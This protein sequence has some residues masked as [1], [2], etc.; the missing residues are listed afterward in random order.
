MRG[1]WGR[2]GWK[3]L[4]FLTALA[5]MWWIAKRYLL[6]G[7]NLTDRE[8]WEARARLASL[9]KAPQWKPGASGLPPC[10]FVV[11]QSA[12]QQPVATGSISD[13]LLLVPDGRSLNLYEVPLG[14]RAVIPITTDLY[15]PDVIPLAFT[16]TC[17]PLDEWAKRHQVYLPHVYDPY[18]TGSRRPYNYSDWLLPDRQTIHYERISAGTGYADAI[19]EDDRLIPF[20]LG[21]RIKWNGWGWDLSLEDGSTYLSPEAYAA[22]RPQQGSLVG[23]FDKNGNEV[24]LVRASNGDLKKIVSPSGRTINLQYEKGRVSSA[25]DDSGNLVEYSYD[26]TNQVEAVRY[27][28]GRKIQYTYDSYG[29]IATVNDT[30]TGFTLGGLYDSDGHLIEINLGNGDAYTFAYHFQVADG[31]FDVDITGPKDKVIRV[32]MRSVDGRTYYKSQQNTH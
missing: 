22:K 6:T 1:Y 13:C 7:P 25:S 8:K 23:I 21:S 29:H 16:R 18:L 14:A 32:N 30:Q 15:V 27:S 31:S 20:F 24:R 17:L 2:R 3:D 12:T 26:Q 11:P 9:D 4:L 19:Y 28:S 5:V 10:F